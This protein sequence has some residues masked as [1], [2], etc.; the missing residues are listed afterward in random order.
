MAVTDFGSLDVARKRVWAADIWVA[1]RDANF[2]MSQGFVGTS[3]NNVIERITELTR[4]ERGD[5]CIMQLVA[6]LSGDGVIGDNVLEG[7]E[8]ALFN[9]AI[10]LH[11][12]QLRHGVRTKGQMAEQ[13]TV[14]R[15]R[16]TAKE[17]LSFWYADKMDE[18][19]FLTAAG[20]SYGLKVDGS[21]RV[22]SQLA[23]LKFA[24]DVVAP[25]S[26]RIR[27]AN[28]ATSLATLS[29]SD[30]LSWNMCLS[31]QAF[32]K[33]K[34]MKPIRA[35]GK[36]YY[37]FLMSTEQ[38]RDLKSDATYQQNVGRAA[39]RGE[40][41]P[42]FK[43]A[44][45]TI[46]GLVIFE[47]NKVPNTLGLA[48]GSKWGVGGTVD[49]AQAMLLGAQAIGLAMLGEMSYE[50][51]DNTDYHNRPGIAVGRMI[52]LLKPQFASLTDL[53]GG[54]ATKQDFGVVSLYTAA[55]PTA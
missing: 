49:G 22:G 31:L 5:E 47:H 14:I 11:I 8:E 1:G 21:T 35:A 54:I 30:K 12:D 20:I 51:S 4:T 38:L 48:S 10:S 9:D 41:N 6:D 39:A 34:R 50:E 37:A 7:S 44:V 15:F 53:S 40:S 18:M 33:R 13:R 17:K 24:A 3:K 2:W 28:A 32:A 25:S 29:T 16:S 52:G 46:D 45:A 27:Y 55:A 43:A 42:L 19:T 23:S 36:E 26:G